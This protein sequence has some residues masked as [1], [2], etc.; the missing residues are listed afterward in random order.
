MGSDYNGNE[1]GPVK[2]TPQQFTSPGNYP[3][4]DFREGDILTV[5]GHGT[6]TPP[7]RYAWSGSGWVPM[8]ESAECC[9]DPGDCV[10][11]CTASRHT[12]EAHDSRA[13]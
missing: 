3:P 7:R 13:R 6:I 2:Y 11:S 1:S 8:Q 5:Y 9:G 10:R 4:N 12:P